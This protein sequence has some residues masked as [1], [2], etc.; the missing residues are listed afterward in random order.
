M[1]KLKE[2]R[3]EYLQIS[4][5]PTNNNCEDKSNN[6]ARLEQSRLIIIR[7]KRLLIEGQILTDEKLKQVTTLLELTEQKWR[8][9]DQEGKSWGK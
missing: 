5:P 1:N 4:R 9:L 6:D 8:L 3:Q 2:L 7:M